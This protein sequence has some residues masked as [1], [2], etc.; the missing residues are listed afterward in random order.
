MLLPFLLL[1][2]SC[3]VSLPTSSRVGESSMSGYIDGNKSNP[4]EKIVAVTSSS[5]WKFIGFAPHPP[6]NRIDRDSTSTQY[7]LEKQGERI[8][9][10]FLHQRNTYFVFNIDNQW[11]SFDLD[12][13]SMYFIIYQFDFDENYSKHKIPLPFKGGLDELYFG[14]TA[15][16]IVWREVNMGY[17]EYNIK[18]QAITRHYFSPSKSVFDKLILISK[19]RSNIAELDFFKAVESEVYSDKTIDPLTIVK[20]DSIELLDN[21][22][23]S[24]NYLDRWAI[25]LN[26]HTSKD[27][28]K[29]L[30]KDDSYYVASAAHKRLVQQF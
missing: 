12:D 4:D 10:D 8:E 6:G 5:V 15:K 14:K 24:K 17:Q 27:M 13:D 18:K 23:R 22:S 29:T 9:L 16:I 3:G 28:L 21:A 1:L 25:A 2:N 30:S 7:F 19:G 26:P 11:F 20:S